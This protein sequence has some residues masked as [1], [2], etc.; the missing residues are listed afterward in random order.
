[1][2]EKFLIT[3]AG[4]NAQGSKNESAF[5]EKPEKHRCSNNAEESLVQALA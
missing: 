2:I 5:I 4:Q 1:M 3:V